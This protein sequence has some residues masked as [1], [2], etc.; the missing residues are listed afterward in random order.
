M[1]SLAVHEVEIMAL[2]GNLAA[3]IGRAIENGAAREPA[4]AKPMLKAAATRMHEL[5]SA[6]P[7]AAPV[8]PGADS[9]TEQSPGASPPEQR[10][11]GENALRPGV[12]QPA[13]EPA[14]SA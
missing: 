13:S 8:H 5:A 12:A 4:A 14:P 2:I 11:Q 10:P 9:Q 6:L 1:V 7:D 3:N